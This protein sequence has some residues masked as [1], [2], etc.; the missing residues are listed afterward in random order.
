MSFLFL[1]RVNKRST[2]SVNS[3]LEDKDDYGNHP[4]HYSALNG[5]VDTTIYLCE[6][7][8][9]VGARNQLGWTPLDCAASRGNTKVMA[10]LLDADA[11]IDPIDKAKLTPLHLAAKNG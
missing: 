9:E 8:A 11:E 7:G 1:K 10:A 3:Q 4:L 6:M 5:H 2:E